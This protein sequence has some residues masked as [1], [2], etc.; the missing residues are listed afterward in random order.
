MPTRQGYVALAA[1]IVALVVARVFG[2]LELYVVGAAFVVVVAAGLLYVWTRTP[3]VDARRWIHPSVLVAG[4]VGRVDLELENRGLR[5]PRFQLHE[6]VSRSSG[7]PD[8]VA[9]LRVEPFGAGSTATAG[10]RLP[11]TTRGL[12]TL[13]PLTAE[14]RDPLGVTRRQRLVGGHDRVVIAPRAHRL[15]VPD[16]GVGPLGRHLLASAR[17]LGQGEFHSLREYVDGDEPRTIHW[18]ASARSDELLVKQHTVEGLRRV[19]VAL[20]RSPSS[21]ADDASF[22]RAIVVAASTVRS[23]AEADLTTRFVTSGGVDLRGPEV[24]DLTLGVLAEITVDADPPRAM[25]RDPSDGIGLL[26]VISGRGDSPIAGAVAGMIDPTLTVL[27]VTT[28]QA[29][30]GDLGVGA[31]TEDEFVRSWRRLAGERVSPAATVGPA[32]AMAGAHR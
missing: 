29:A 16:L 22:E 31:R 25:E 1:G 21:Y 10:Y 24:A 30:R 2:V 27:P 20:D 14:L 4:D 32:T 28:D 5:T 7:G 9:T 3:R 6:R 11:T 13:G 15:T 23:S 8:H 19:V 26:I 17:R 12:V 18:R